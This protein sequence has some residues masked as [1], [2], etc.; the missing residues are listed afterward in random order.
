MRIGDFRW[1]GG[2]GGDSI[3]LGTKNSPL[4]LHESKTV[5]S[6]KNL[7]IHINVFFYIRY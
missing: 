7:T 5:N 4:P 1:P 3:E 2:R 6:K